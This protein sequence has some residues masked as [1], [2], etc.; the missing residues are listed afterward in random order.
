MNDQS[1]NTRKAIYSIIGFLFR[2]KT[3]A[4]LTSLIIISLIGMLGFKIFYGCNIYAEDPVCSTN[5][6]SAIYKILIVL[7]FSSA[8]YL[9]LIAMFRD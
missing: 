8:L 9:W 3:N 2:D 5:Q 7:N 6:I 4:S 1:G